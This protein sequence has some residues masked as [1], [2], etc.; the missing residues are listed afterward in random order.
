LFGLLRNWR[1]DRARKRP[2]PEEWRE[3]LSKNVPLYRRLPPALRATVEGHVQVLLAEKRF[4]GCGGLELTDEI[5]VTIAGHAA[6]L[7]LGRARDFYPRLS[8]ILVYPSAYRVNASRWGPGGIVTEGVEGRLGESWSL[9]ALVVAW[10]EVLSDALGPHDGKNVALHEFAHQLD[11]EDRAANG[12]PLLGGRGLYAAWSRVLGA[13]YERLRRG[14]GTVLDPYGATD[15]AEFFAVATEAFF[16]KPRELK[17]WNP[18]L[19]DQ[20]SSYY[21][22]DLSGDPVR[23]VDTS[24]SLS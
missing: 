2:F 21:G 4:E 24:E 23:L 22:L 1:R 5:R 9:G 15:P 14:I 19:Y 20:L 12:T 3:V 7:L 10:D 13:E 17:A 11:Q 18:E 6:L 8:S 16:E